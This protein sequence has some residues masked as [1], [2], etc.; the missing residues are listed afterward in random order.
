MKRLIVGVVA[1]AVVMVLRPLVKR[2]VVQK[3]GEHC[4]QMAANCQGMME[5][6]SE[7]TGH[8][9]EVRRMHR[10]CEE[11]SAQRGEDREPVVT[12]APILAGTVV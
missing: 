12:E 8:E 7:T 5:G 1:V 2:R 9:A 11:T 3:L 6:R 10:H 4:K